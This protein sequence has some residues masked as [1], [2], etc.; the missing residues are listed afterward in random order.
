MKIG[1]DSIIMDTDAHGLDYVVRS[2]NRKDKQGGLVDSLSANTS[3]ITICD[4]VF[5]GTRCIV[6]KGVTIG[7]RTV[8]GSGSVVTKDIPENCIAAGNPCRIIRQF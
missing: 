8:I 3:P 4:D 6:L 2:S 7:A 1:A 5:I